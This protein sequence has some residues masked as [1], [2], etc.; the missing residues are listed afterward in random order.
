M[1][2][3]S[4][5]T[6]EVDSDELWRRVGLAELRQALVRTEELMVRFEQTLQTLPPCTTCARAKLLE[7][8]ERQ[9]G[10]LAQEMTGLAVLATTL[11]QTLVTL[12]QAE[13]ALQQNVPAPCRCRTDVCTCHE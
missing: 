11:K 6:R 3:M 12:E 10:R 7:Q 4:G 9:T 13:A 8:L 2:A 5:P 1:S